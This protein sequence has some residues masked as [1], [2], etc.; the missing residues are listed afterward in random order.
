MSTEER[1]GYAGLGLC[2]LIALTTVVVTVQAVRSVGNMEFSFKNASGMSGI[3]TGQSAP[4]FALTDLDGNLVRLSDYR[5][6]VVLLD[7]WATWCAP[8]VKEL[9][10]IQRIHDQYR[11]KGLIVLAIST[12]Q[13]KNAVRSFW[14]DNGYTFPTLYADGRV[15]SAYEVRGI[16]A[17]YLIDREGVVRFHK[18]GYGPGGEREIEREVVELL[19]GG[20]AVAGKREG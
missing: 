8:C 16:P 15:Q 18:T 11:E 4:D 17:L 5:G 19:V 3:P 9:P 1:H 13:Q 2:V 6:N 14:A 10:H 7:F 12:D 20:P